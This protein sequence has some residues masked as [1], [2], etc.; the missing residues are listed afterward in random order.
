MRIAFVSRQ[1]LGRLS[2]SSNSSGKCGDAYAAYRPGTRGAGNSRKEIEGINRQIEGFG[3]RFTDEGM[4]NTTAWPAIIHKAFLRYAFIHGSSRLT[5]PRALLGL[6][7]FRGR[8]GPNECGMCF[9]KSKTLARCIGR[10]KT[11]TLTALGR[12]DAAGIIEIKTNRDPFTQERRSSNYRFDKS[13]LK[14]MRMG[15]KAGVGAWWPSDLSVLA[16]V[17]EAIKVRHGYAQF[18]TR[19]NSTPPAWSTAGRHLTAYSDLW[20][21]LSG[22]SLGS[23]MD[24]SRSECCWKAKL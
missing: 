11:A 7:S 10:S 1:N 8:A 5:P 3:G 13:L 21:R 6:Y 9:P 2:H 18:L 23:A 4:I 19:M 20:R 14:H 17:L 15:G 12:I 16:L 24:A 22:F